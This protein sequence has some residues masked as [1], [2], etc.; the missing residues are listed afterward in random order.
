MTGSNVQDGYADEGEDE[1]GDE[2]R[3]DIVGGYA[4]DDGVSPLWKRI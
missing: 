2:D 1:D 3:D 4:G